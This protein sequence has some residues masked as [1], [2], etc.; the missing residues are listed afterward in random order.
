[1]AIP[2]V[3]PLIRIFPATMNNKTRILYIL[4]QPYKWLVFLP[5][6]LV[7][8]CL[9]VLLGMLLIFF[10]DD[11]AANRIA[12]VWW[13]RFNS[14][15]TPMLVRVHG[16]DTISPKQSYIVVANHQSHYDIFVLYGW[17]GIDLKWVIKK[18]LRTI[19][20]FGFAG[21][22]GGNIFID[23]S[24]PAAAYESLEQ[25]RQKIVNGTSIIILPEGTRTRTGE[26]GEFKRGAFWLAQHLNIPILPVTILNTRNILPPRTF[27][28]FPGRAIM[29]IH[30][31]ID[32]VSYGADSLDRLIYDVR[33]VIQDGLINIE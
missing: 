24:N 32:T 20:V 26:L 12:G 30:P 33:A 29:K 23:R 8:T 18:E 11:Y 16:R 1:M 15:I 7:S 4:Y 10:I 6:L 3:E 2:F 13:A 25:A 14:I 31:P 9:F 17:L 28:L 5:L 22:K 21:E 27:N 19:P